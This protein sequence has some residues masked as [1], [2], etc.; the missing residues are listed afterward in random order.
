MDYRTTD[1]HYQRQHSRAMQIRT[2][3]LRA[4][5]RRLWMIGIGG[6]R[7]VWTFEYMGT[8]FRGR[9]LYYGYRAGS[10]TPK[11]QKPSRGPALRLL[12]YLGVSQGLEAHL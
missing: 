3:G 4:G 12:T 6:V 11:P 1:N 7:Q 9:A 2:I 8:D 5:F 10:D